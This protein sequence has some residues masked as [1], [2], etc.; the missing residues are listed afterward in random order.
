MSSEKGTK[1]IDAQEHKLFTIIITLEGFEK[2]KTA[3]TDNKAVW[4]ISCKHLHATFIFA[5]NWL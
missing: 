5:Q 4:I 1:H 2:I 3:K